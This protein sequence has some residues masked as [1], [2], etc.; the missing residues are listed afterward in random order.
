MVD[1]QRY[2]SEVIGKILSEKLLLQMRE[3]GG[4]WPR[5]VRAVE[6]VLF[7]DKKRRPCQKGRAVCELKVVAGFNYPF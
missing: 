2:L 5:E 3:T 6:V 4:D 7:L 1:A